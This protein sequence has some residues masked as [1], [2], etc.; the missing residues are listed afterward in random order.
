MILQYIDASSAHQGLGYGRLDTVVWRI[1]PCC[2]LPLVSLGGNLDLPTHAMRG[3][4]ISVIRHTFEIFFVKL[5]W[6][7]VVLKV[8]T[9]EIQEILWCGWIMQTL[10][11]KE[12][13]WPMQ[14]CNQLLQWA[15]PSRMPHLHRILRNDR[16]K[17]RLMSSVGVRSGYPKRW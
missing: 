15:N 5:C 2:E 17:Q 11:I 10:P 16:C 1:L 6:Y 9:Q 4:H 12:K 14:D 3:K 7:I 8:A 13:Q